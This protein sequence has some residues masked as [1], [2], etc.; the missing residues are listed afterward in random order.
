MAS[1][2]GWVR[3]RAAVGRPG[4]PARTQEPRHLCSVLRPPAASACCLAA[5]GPARNGG[6]G[7]TPGRRPSRAGAAPGPR[8]AAASLARPGQSPRLP[9]RPSPPRPLIL[10]YSRGS[11]GDP[12]LN[13]QTEFCPQGRSGRCSRCVLLEHGGRLVLACKYLLMLAVRRG[14]GA[15]MHLLWEGLRTQQGQARAASLV[16]T[17]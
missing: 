5:R 3:R 10:L 9:Q 2:S 8:A 15:R 17:G 7:D 14:E 12:P 11:R 13:R 4:R 16:S 1:S 6:A